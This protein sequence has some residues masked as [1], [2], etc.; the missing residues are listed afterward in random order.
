MLEI[1]MEINFVNCNITYL[2]QITVCEYGKR[3]NSYNLRI[4]ISF[5]ERIFVDIAE[6]ST[7]FTKIS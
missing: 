5:M 2:V 1:L 4:H 6:K 3:A 7:N